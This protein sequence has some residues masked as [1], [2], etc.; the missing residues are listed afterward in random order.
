MTTKTTPARTVLPGTLAPALELPMVG[1]E[2]FRLADRA[3]EL[4][5]LLVFN[6]GLHCPVCHAQ[7]S[8]RSAPEPDSRQTI[9]SN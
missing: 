6:R 3:P 8:E 2:P 9:R 1:G 7:L 5:T 4:F